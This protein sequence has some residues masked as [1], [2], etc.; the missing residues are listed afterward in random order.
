LITKNVLTCSIFNEKKLYVFLIGDLFDEGL[1]S[2]EQDFNSY[3]QT[4]KYLFSVPPE[5]QLYTVVGN[6]DIGFHYRYINN[7]FIGLYFMKI[8]KLVF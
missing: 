2:S 8:I 1:W 6:H 5:I 7:L 4:F 3:V